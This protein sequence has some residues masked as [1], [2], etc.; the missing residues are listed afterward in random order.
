MAYRLGARRA[1]VWAPQLPGG[2]PASRAHTVGDPVFGDPEREHRHGDAVLLSDQARLTANRALQ[3]RH[4]VGCPLHQI[5]K[6]PRDLLGAFD[7]VERR[8]D[9]TAAVGN[10]LRAGVQEADKRPYIPG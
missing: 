9:E 5:G 2:P 3:E 8:A 7:R 6:V 1:A 4:A 10:R